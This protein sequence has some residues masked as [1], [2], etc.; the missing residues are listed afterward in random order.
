MPS[1]DQRPSSAATTARCERPRLTFNAGIITNT[2]QR[3]RCGYCG[4][5]LCDPCEYHPHIACEAFERTHD[6]REVWREL[7]RRI[8]AHDEALPGLERLLKGGADLA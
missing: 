4:M 5:G 7:H 1:P 8:K 2:I 6:S 3:D